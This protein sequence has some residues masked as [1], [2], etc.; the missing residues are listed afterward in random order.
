M[1][2][3]QETCK[4][5]EI[6][7]KK[8]VENKLPELDVHVVELIKD[9]D[10][11]EGDEDKVSSSNI[12]RHLLGTL[13]KPPYSSYNPNKPYVIGLTGGLASGKSTIRTDLEKMG[14]ATIDC[15]KLGKIL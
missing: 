5:G 6:I 3:S 8:R 7:N 11:E 1:I 15:D 14:V 2:V 9:E 10:V 13:I 12:R 4:T